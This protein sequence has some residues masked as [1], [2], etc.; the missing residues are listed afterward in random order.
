MF[1]EEDDLLESPESPSDDAESAQGTMS[2]EL[3]HR[4]ARNIRMARVADA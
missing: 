2:F 4:I 1:R 3:R